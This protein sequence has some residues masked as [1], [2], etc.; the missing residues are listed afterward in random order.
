MM[1][2][3]EFTKTSLIPKA[4]EV[5][6]QYYSDYCEG[7]DIDIQTKVDESPASRADREAEKEL[8]ALINQKYPEHGIWGEEFGGENLD[9]EYIW[10]LDPLDGTRQFLNKQEGCFVVLVGLFKNKKPYIG[11]ASDP[12]SKEIWM[13]CDAVNNNIISI[14]EMVVASTA[15]IRMFEGHRYNDNI[16][17]FF[18]DVKEVIEH[19]NAKSFLDVID[20]RAHVGIESSLSIHDIGALIPVCSRAGCVVTDFEGNDYTGQE[21]EL[22][23]DKY[24]FLVTRN[25][26]TTNEILK[27]I[28]K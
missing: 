13:E 11:A 7:K 5:L 19:R 1:E 16:Q 2:F 9:A 21:F 14:E 15:S 10:V 12:L 17:K 28:R 8:R 6:S 23:R 22:N 27:E 20:G 25:Q 24:D 4:N 26:E 3:Q 18:T